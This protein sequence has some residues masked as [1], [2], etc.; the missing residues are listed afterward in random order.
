MKV[1]I[2]CEYS[3]RVREEFRK[4]GH[5]AWSC[6]LL[7]SEDKSPYHIV[8]DCLSLLGDGWDLMIAHPP[9]T[10]L[11]N[12][13]V[14]WLHERDLWSEL[15]DAVAFYLALRNAPIEKKCLENPVMHKYARERLGEVPR[16]VVQ[17]WWFGDPTFKATGYELHGLPELVPTDKLTPPA[18]G[19]EEH[20]AWSWIHRCPPGPERWKIRSRTPHG[21]ARA[22]ALQWGVE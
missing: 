2:A 16:Q 21:I 13:G 14:R 12:S 17:P 9:C 18:I 4:L 22:M 7:E 3:G 19:T 15:D 20:K 8:G 6:D 5:D 1:L 10:R 11:A